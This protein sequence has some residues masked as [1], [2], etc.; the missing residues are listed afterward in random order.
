MKY[1]DF[2]LQLS[3][4]D[5]EGYQVAV[6][7]SPAGFPANDMQLSLD[8]EAILSE[9][10]GHLEG[11]GEPLDPKTPLDPRKL[12]DLRRQ[13]GLPLFTRLFTEGV[14]VAFQR[15]RTSVDLRRS[16]GEDCVLR[17]RLH[18]G[19]PAAQAPWQNPDLQRDLLRIATLPWEYLCEPEGKFLALSSWLPIVRRFD[20]REL[21]D[22]PAVKPPIRILVASCL[23]RDLP[24]LKLAKP[25]QQ[26]LW[27][28]FGSGRPP[29]VW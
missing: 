9:A 25:P 8:P 11:N 10:W 27:V 18:F 21:V 1:L 20:T 16:N 5:Q 24:P 6:T 22:F 3:T 12:V 13:L 7:Q 23:P 14:G 4:T 26:N 28:K 19:R 2:T 17:L 29:S 15:A